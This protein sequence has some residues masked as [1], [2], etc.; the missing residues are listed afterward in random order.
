L[1]RANANGDYEFNLLVF[2]AAAATAATGP[3]RFSLDNLYGWAD[4]I[5][6]LWWGVGVVGVAAVVSAL[7]LTVGRGAWMG[8]GRAGA[9]AAG[10]ARPGSP[11]TAAR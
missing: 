3:G 2:T 8:R 6:G 1:S 5:S 11:G 4:N 9:Q 7:T 10:D